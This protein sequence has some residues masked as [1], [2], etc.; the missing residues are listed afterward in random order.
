[1]QGNYLSIGMGKLDGRKQVVS[2]PFV[3]INILIWAFLILIPFMIYR[4]NKEKYKDIVGFISAA[5]LIIELVAIT[6]SFIQAIM[7]DDGATMDNRIHNRSPKIVSKANEFVFSKEKNYLIILADEYDSFCFDE[8]V[9]QQPDSIDGFDGFTYYTN[10]VGMYKYTERAI[11]FLLTGEQTME[12][13]YENGRDSLFKAIKNNY[14]MNIY[15]STDVFNEKIY[16]EYSENIITREIDTS[17]VINT[18][19]ILYRVTFMKY[20]PSVFRPLF[21]VYSDDFNNSMFDMQSYSFYDLDF[22]ETLDSELYITDVPQFK[23]VYLYGLHDPRNVSAD[24]TLEDN[25]SVSGDEQAIAVNKILSKY[26][27]KLQE[28]GVYDNT[29]IVLLADHGLKDHDDGAYPLLM[30]KRANADFEGIQTSDAPIS[31]TEVYPTLMMLAGEDTG[32]DTVYDID[33]NA[34]RKRYFAE[35]DRYF[36]SNIK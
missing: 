14:Q 17:T 3:I 16:D 19:A 28:N 30:I 27:K 5:I 8:A 11:P 12:P 1:M 22:Y 15:A 6:V 4:F 13:T 33:E 23:F 29:E 9:R 18:G 10:T 21:Y 31:Q 20:L 34:D 24:L 2:V 26:F 36:D 25:W 7:I 35:T 32:R